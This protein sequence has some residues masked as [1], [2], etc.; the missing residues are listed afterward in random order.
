MSK[1]IK[2]VFDVSIL[3][4]GANKNATRSGIFFTVHNI[5]KVLLN[6]TDI[7]LQLYV[8]GVNN[9]DLMFYLN[10]N[11]PN[12]TFKFINKN[13]ARGIY[14]KL[15]H[16]KDIYK[17]EN[18]LLKKVLMQILLC[19]L[20]PISKLLNKLEN[21]SI[22]KKINECDAYLSLMFKKPKGVKIKSYNM[23]YDL[24]PLLLPAHHNQ[25]FAKGDWL[26]GLCESLNKNDY[27][28]AISEATKND[29]LKYYPIIDKNKIQTTYLACNESFK[30]ESNDK[31]IL[32]KEK[33]NIPLDKKYV[34]SLC[35][36]EPRKNLIRTVKTFVEFIK[37]NDINDLVFVL[38]GGHWE[39]F[40]KKLEQE[41]TNL[42]DFSGKIIKI[43]YVDDEDLAALYSGAEWFTYTSRYE[44]FGLPPLEAMSCGCP[45]ITSNN[46][47]LPEVVGDAGILIDWDSDEQHINAYEKYYFDKN[48]REEN[49]KKGLERVKQFSWEKCT[50]EIMNVILSE[51]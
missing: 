6:K 49:S 47:S 28:F 48:L 29:F 51:R 34:F 20:S 35:T 25:T 1:K 5:F 18:K 11:F 36:L 21:I 23:L 4:N 9:D 27:Y 44:G 22:V 14:K 38:G 30:Q 7:D 3:A 2:L 15:K 8:N 13:L 40:I 45:V 32:A 24:V 19:I 16:Q 43:G 37:K 17:Q 10:E 31:I 50:N 26:Y 46:T 39:M 33:Y 41:I 12:V 42:K